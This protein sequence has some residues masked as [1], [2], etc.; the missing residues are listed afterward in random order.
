ML[1]DFV[2]V[3]PTRRCQQ[4]LLGLSQPT[5]I[6]CH[7]PR[8]S[9]LLNSRTGPHG[10]IK[11]DVQLMKRKRTVRHLRNLLPRFSLGEF[12]TVGDKVLQNELTYGVGGCSEAV[13]GIVHRMIEPRTRLPQNL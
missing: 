1:L 11:R 13:L 2:T 12:L 6:M 8:E 10:R 9:I 7:P 5:L 3:L 4:P